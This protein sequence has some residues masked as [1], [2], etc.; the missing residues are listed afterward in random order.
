[1]VGV[2]NGHCETWVALG[3]PGI[4]HSAF[5]ADTS[6]SVLSCLGR[7]EGQTYTKMSKK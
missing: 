1:M 5:S 3:V 2:N 4:T 7:E 6:T